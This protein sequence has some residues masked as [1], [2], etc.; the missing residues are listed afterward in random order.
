M[1]ASRTALSLILTEEKLGVT[2][3]ATKAEVTLEKLDTGFTITAVHLDLKGKVTGVDAARFREL[4]K[5]AEE[6]RPLSKVIRAN[7]TMTA[8]LL[9]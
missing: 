2:E 9:A 4:A 1:A 3:L 8:E 6:N 7:I 5:K